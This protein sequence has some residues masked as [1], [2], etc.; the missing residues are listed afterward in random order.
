MSEKDQDDSV[1]KHVDSADVLRGL[2][3]DVQTRLI[4]KTVGL[5][6][7]LTGMEGHN[8]EEFPEEGA[9][10]GLAVAQ[11]E[12]HLAV[13]ISVMM[14]TE[15]LHVR[16]DTSTEYRWDEPLTLSRDCVIEFLRH[17]AVNRAL[18]TSCAHVVDAATQVSV[19]LENISFEFEDQ[20]VKMVD[21]YEPTP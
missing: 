6:E 17:E 20:V 9:S 11:T 12:K 15:T 5:R 1:A 14:T 21:A 16:A 13:R 18:T 10:I 4:W 2:V 19:R 3:D 7:G 8:L